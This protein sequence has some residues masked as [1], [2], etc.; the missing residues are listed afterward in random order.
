M[1]RSYI[2][3][4]YYQDKFIYFF[5]VTTVIQNNH[6]LATGQFCSIFQVF[7]HLNHEQGITSM[8]IIGAQQEAFQVTIF[9]SLKF[10]LISYSDL[11]QFV[12]QRIWESIVY[13]VI[14]LSQYSR[15]HRSFLCISTQFLHVDYK[16]F[17]NFAEPFLIRN[18]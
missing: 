5:F 11:L 13:P 18:N 15:K 16:F 12:I 17:L 6:I 9:I 8:V 14:H 1:Y 7:S 3:T 10:S 4:I 2:C